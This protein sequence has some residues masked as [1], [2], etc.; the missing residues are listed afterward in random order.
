[1][2]TGDFTGSQTNI[3][4]LMDFYHLVGESDNK[5]NTVRWYVYGQK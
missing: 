3:P 2:G 1:M 5:Q 4:A